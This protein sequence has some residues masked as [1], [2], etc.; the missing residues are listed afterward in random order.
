MIMND[1]DET[2]FETRKKEAATDEISE[3]E[4]LDDGRRRDHR[5]ESVRTLTL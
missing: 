5:T 3:T 4:M 1:T 2:S